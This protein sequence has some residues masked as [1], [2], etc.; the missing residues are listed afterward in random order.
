M[1]DRTRRLQTEHNKAQRA[2]IEGIV[3]LAGR[4]TENTRETDCEL[5]SALIAAAVEIYSRHK[6]YAEIVEELRSYAD[7]IEAVVRK[8]HRQTGRIA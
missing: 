1:S 4:S 3:A 8:E 5:A 6:P 7:H 2:L